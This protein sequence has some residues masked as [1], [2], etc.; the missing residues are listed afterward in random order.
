M[1]LLCTWTQRSYIRPIKLV[2]YPPPWYRSLLSRYG[3]LLMSDIGLFGVIYVSFYVPGPSAAISGQSNWSHIRPHGCC[4]GTV[5]T[6]THIHTRTHMHTPTRSRTRARARTHTR[7][8]A[9]KDI[10]IHNAHTHKWFKGRA[11]LHIMFYTSHSTSCFT[12]HTPHHV[13]HIHVLHIL[14]IMFYTSTSCFTLILWC[15][16]KRAQMIQMWCTQT[17]SCIFCLLI[18]HAHSQY[19]YI[20]LYIYIRT[21]IYIHTYIH[22][23][24]YIYIYIYKHIYIYK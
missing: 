24:I 19:I 9:R 23:Y 8:H 21:Y 10:Y 22:T 13:L 1:S 16:E 20:Y 3:S 18:R 7:T 5:H 14:H 12:H 15:G 11:F 17:I 4:C 2:T 6:H